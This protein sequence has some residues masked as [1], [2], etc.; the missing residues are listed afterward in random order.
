VNHDAW[1]I[2]NMGYLG[3]TSRGTEVAVN[4]IAAEADRLIL[5][6]GVI[7]HSMAGFGGGRKS[8]LPGVAALKTIQR[9]HLLALTHHVGGGTNPK[10]ASTVTTGNPMHEDMMEI[11]AF[12]KPDFLIN[13]Y[14]TF[15]KM[16]L[17][18]SR[19]PS[20]MESWV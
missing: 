19:T 11:A 12:A 1:Q 3:K 7:Y 8:I 14:Q 15:L 18:P 10:S 2:E 16:L 13:D 9:N 6:G 5:T 17:T 20:T 4:R